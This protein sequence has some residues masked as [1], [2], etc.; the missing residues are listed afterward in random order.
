MKQKTILKQSK[1]S[2]ITKRKNFE[3]KFY[4]SLLDKRSDFISVLI[5]LGDAYTRKGFYQKGLSVDRKLSRLLP[6]DTIV[7][8]NL[9]C[10]LSLVGEPNKALGELK[11][12]I[13]LGYDDFLYIRKD[14]DLAN[15][16]ELPE[17]KS[18]FAKLKKLI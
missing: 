17:F 2:K 16:R 13:L 1:A 7:H 4:E 6:D 12:A 10:S 8:Y 9:A 3:I 11:K 5:P 15:L 14:P 18:F